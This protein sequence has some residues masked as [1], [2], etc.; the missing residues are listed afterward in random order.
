MELRLGCGAARGT[1]CM[2]FSS[3]TFLFVFL[4]VVLLLTWA[5]PGRARRFVL[6]AAGLVFYAWGVQ[7]FVLLVMA[8]T[9]VDWGLAL[10]IERTRKR[11]LLIAAVGQNLLL[12]GTFK[13]AS[14]G[15]HQINRLADLVGADGVGALSIVLPIGI[16]FFTFEKISYVVDV[17]RGDVRA[18][19]D[20]LDVLLFVSL[21]P[22]S[23]AGPIVRLR[24]I[25]VDLREPRP[26]AEQVQAGAIRFSYGLAKKVLIADQIAPIADAAFASAGDGTLTS[27]AA[28]IGLVAYTLQLYF[29]FSGY[30]DMAIGIGMML[31][32]RFPE[33]FA[34][35]YSSVSMTDF[36]RRW[37]MT[38]SRWFRDYVYIPLG[39]SRH[40]D[41]TTYRNLFIVFALV[42]L[43][44]GAGWV[45][46]AWGLYHGAWLALERRMGWRAFSGEAARP[47]LRRAATVLIVMLGWVLFRAETPGVALDY[48]VALVS[49]GDGGTT[50]LDAALSNRAV[51]CMAIA[52]LVVLL[53]AGRAGGAWVA[54]ASGRVPSLARFATVGVALPLALLAAMAGT[55]SPF[56]YFQF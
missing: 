35:P 41:A 19:R 4:P 23:I 20:P 21:F 13:Y 55:F 49:F 1:P 3:Q 24:E 12:L 25:A 54:E 46:L 56:L 36:W 40:G 32:F 34:R 27:T 18:R 52:S 43:W 39:G 50:V 15:V 16:S 30:T 53:P 42:G 38:L 33:N 8:S 5:A 11:W 47:W 29:D 17:W 2:V 6:L 48:Y 26:R 10:A 44:H 51:T 14:F 37:H 31:G 45:F 22:R 7:E 9:L 28:W